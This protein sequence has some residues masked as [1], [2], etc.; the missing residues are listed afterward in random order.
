MGGLELFY[1]KKFLSLSSEYKLQLRRM[2]LHLKYACKLLEKN[3]MNELWSRKSIHFSQCVN[4]EQ[5]SHYTGTRKLYLKK[6]NYVY[7][8]ILW[9]IYLICSITYEQNIYEF[10]FP[11]WICPFNKT[12]D[13][14]GNIILLILLIRVKP[15]SS[16]CL[17]V[18]E[19]WLMK[20]SQLT[21]HV[22]DFHISWPVSDI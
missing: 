8:P 11:D 7:V 14:I 20:T 10:L 13:T 3:L 22:Y 12:K 15:S 21:L 18:I 19:M 2:R 5:S 16:Y 17:Y 1:Y 4:I 6:F 9:L